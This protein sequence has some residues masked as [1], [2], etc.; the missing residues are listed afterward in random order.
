M[1]EEKIYDLIGT[2]INRADCSN[3]IVRTISTI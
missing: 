3:N 2:T 1:Q